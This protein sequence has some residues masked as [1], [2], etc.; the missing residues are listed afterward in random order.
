MSNVWR[1]LLVAGGI[2]LAVGIGHS[3]SAATVPMGRQCGS[4]QCGP[5][6]YCSP[7]NDQCVSC[8][9]IC[10]QPSHNYDEQQC[11]SQC[12]GMSD[13]ARIIEDHII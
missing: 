10:T 6:D 12:D 3:S 9:R 11:A 7:L 8:E 5:L 13:H 1:R 2:A 4:K